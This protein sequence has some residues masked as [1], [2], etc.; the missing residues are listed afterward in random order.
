MAEYICFEYVYGQRGTAY[1]LFI[2]AILYM[3]KF[4]LSFVAFRTQRL[5]PSPNYPARLSGGG[6]V[7][8]VQKT[9]NSITLARLLLVS[10]PKEGL[11]IPVLL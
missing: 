4:C 8:K 10:H 11:P 3:G 2:V 9:A 7:Q 1:L 6:L 5:T